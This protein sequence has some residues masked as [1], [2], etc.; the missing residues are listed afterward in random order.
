MLA[1]IWWA[2]VNLPGLIV[3]PVL[4]L[5][6]D[7]DRVGN[8][9]SELLGDAIGP[10]NHHNSQFWSILCRV[11]L[12]LLFE[13][14]VDGVL[15]LAQAPYLRPVFLTIM[16]IHG[17]W[18]CFFRALSTLYVIR[19]IVRD[20]DWGYLWIFLHIL[21]SLYWRK[22]FRVVDTLLL[23]WHTIILSCVS[24]YKWASILLGWRALRVAAL[25][26]RLSV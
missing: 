21:S 7:L 22:Y 4:V 3:A 17:S 14:H 24:N 20:V 13:V 8:T 9:V 12:R 16:L 18:W 5:P 2:L 25:S 1:A 19:G 15:I 6:L 26:T 23:C 10:A 11:K